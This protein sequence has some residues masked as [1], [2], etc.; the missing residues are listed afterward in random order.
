LV[1]SILSELSKSLENEAKSLIKANKVKW[2]PHAL[3][4][5]DNDGVKTDEVKTAIDSLQLIELFWTHGFNSPKC[6]FYLQ[7][8]GKPHFHIVTLLSDDSI[9]I[10]TGYLALDPNKFKG[11]GK[12]RVRDIE[13]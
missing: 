6:V 7:I 4:E 12:T 1:C 2:S 3:T 11:D 9:L 13:K 10:K 8:P 5:L